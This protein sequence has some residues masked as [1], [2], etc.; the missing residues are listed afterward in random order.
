MKTNQHIYFLNYCYDLAFQAITDGNHPFAAIIV[1]DNAIVLTQKNRVNTEYDFTAHA[2]LLLVRRARKNFTQQ[3]LSKAVLYTSTEPCAMCA[4]AIYWSGIKNIVFGCS[5]EQL[6][7]IVPTNLNM[8]AGDILKSTDH[9]I[10]DFSHLTYFK[11]MHQ[12]FWNPTEEHYKS[13]N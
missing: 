13:Y 7:H 11:K 6:S 8:S 10:L 1:I 2:E 5:T 12:R 3:E 4:G 9:H